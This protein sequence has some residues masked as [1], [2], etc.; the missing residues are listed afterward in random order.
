MMVDNMHGER[1][2]NEMREYLQDLE[3]KIKSEL[4]GSFEHMVLGLMALP[5][6]FDAR[7]LRAAMKVG[8]INKAGPLVY[9]F[10]SKPTGYGHV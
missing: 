6:E 3:E 4:R 2:P 10:V 7:E 8:L 1:S 5:Q 9:H